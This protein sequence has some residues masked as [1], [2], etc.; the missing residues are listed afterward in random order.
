[1]HALLFGSSR[2]DMDDQAEEWD[3]KIHALS[4]SDGTFGW[5]HVIKGEDTI[6]QRSV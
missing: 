3:K 4:Q 2:K 6:H 5:G 1:M